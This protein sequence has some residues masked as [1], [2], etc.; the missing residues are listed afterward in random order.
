MNLE[1]LPPAESGGRVRARADHPGPGRPNA[2]WPSIKARR[3]T[4]RTS[5]QFALSGVAPRSTYTSATCRR[6]VDCE[7]IEE[8]NEPDKIRPQE[9]RVVVELLR[10]DAAVF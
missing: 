6:Y 1:V 5:G 7:R 8:G 10:V 4:P 3:C 9:A 2:R